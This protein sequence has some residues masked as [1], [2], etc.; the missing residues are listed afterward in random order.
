MAYHDAYLEVTRARTASSTGVGRTS[1]DNTERLG[2]HKKGVWSAVDATRLMLSD[3]AETARRQWIDAQRRYVALVGG[4]MDFELAETFYNSVTRR[5]SRLSASTSGSS[6]C[7][8][9][10]PPS[11]P[12]TA[13]AKYRNFPVDE[14]LSESVRQILEH[15]PLASQFGDI[16][17]DVERVATEIQAELDEIWDG[18]IDSID[19]LRPV[20]YRNKGAY[21]VGRC[22]GSTGSIR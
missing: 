20:F 16:E 15:S 10:P 19:I 5:C 12:T 18:Y 14:S 6:S 4:R 3:D 7:G 13:P 21:L 8:S 9:D 2:L 11:P 1:D 17:R 22:D